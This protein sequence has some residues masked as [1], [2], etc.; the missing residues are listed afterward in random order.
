MQKLH[1]VD[2]VTDANNKKSDPGLTGSLSI[3][4]A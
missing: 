4:L 2:E 3:F 1:E